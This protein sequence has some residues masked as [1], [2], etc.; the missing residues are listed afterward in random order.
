VTSGATEVVS[1]PYPNAFV[2]WARD[3]EDVLCLSADLTSSCEVDVFRDTYPD[4]FISCG[5]AE[6]NMMGVAAGLAREGF[7]PLVHTFGVF[8]TRRPYDQLAMS[9]AYPKLRVRLMGFLPGLTTP[10]GVTHQAIDDIAL[11]RAT[12]N[13]TVVDTGDA[14]EVETVL[15]AIDAVDGPVYCRVLR[16]EV[17]RL[18]DSPLELGTARVLSEGT[19]VCV[20]SS[21]ICTEEAL[22][23]VA[24]LRAVGVDVAHL[25]VST[26]KPFT[27][28]AVTEAIAGSRS[29]VVTVENHS[30]VGG[31]GSVVAE[32]IAVEG[33]GRRLTRLGLRDRYAYGASREHLLREFGLTARDVITAVD[34]LLDAPSGAQVA[35][36]DGATDGLPS[37]GDRSGGAEDL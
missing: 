7:T 35:D 34:G 11:M 16:K 28:E 27:D 6:Q 14:T 37:P 24:A 15:D 19:D 30:H 13:V 36:L 4:R 3:R 25:H 8:L 33:L 1:R 22:R 31:L 26:L 20:L 2:P 12:P 9:I 5:M 21:G 18:F 23:A 10:G 32:L 29:G 17:P